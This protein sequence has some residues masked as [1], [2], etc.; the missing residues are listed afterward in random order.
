[1][2]LS[3]D[4]ER[5]IRWFVVPIHMLKLLPNGDAAFVALSVG[6]LL[7]ERYYRIITNSQEEEAGDKFRNKAAEELNVYKEFFGA[8][9]STYRNGLMHHGTPQVYERANIKYKW[10]IDVE[11]EEYPTYYDKDGFRFICLNPWKFADFMISKFLNNPHHLN[12]SLIYQLGH[13]FDSKILGKPVRVPL[14]ARYP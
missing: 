12:G 5:F 3:T 2:P 1:M 13:I 6:S 11:F 14:A 10:M 4:L 9:W 8:F 7:C